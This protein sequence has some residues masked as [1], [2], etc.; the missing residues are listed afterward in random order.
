MTKEEAKKLGTTHY[1]E[2][3]NY[4]MSIDR[5]SIIVCYQLIDNEWT[6]PLSMFLN[7]KPL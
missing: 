7:L 5:K 1:D 2:F 4:Y 3:G 6:T